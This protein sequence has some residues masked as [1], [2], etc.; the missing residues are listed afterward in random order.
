[1]SV[2]ASFS[3]AQFTEKRMCGG[4]RGVLAFLDDEA[5]SGCLQRAGL[6]PRS[7]CLA[8]MQWRH[9]SKASKC[10]ARCPFAKVRMLL[11][12]CLSHR[13]GFAEKTSGRRRW[14]KQAPHPHIA[15]YWLAGVWCPIGPSPLDCSM[16]ASLGHVP[17]R[18][19]MHGLHC[20]DAG[21][22]VAPGV[23]LREPRLD[24]RRVQQL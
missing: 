2:R 9:P 17:A 19:H 6:E 10:Q 12:A 21:L 14:N 16:H 5:L 22:Q 7:V 18:W 13:T 24:A 3:Q 23:G 1:V 4:L 8:K 15:L 20:T 11:A